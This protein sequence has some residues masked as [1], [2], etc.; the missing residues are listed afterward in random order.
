MQWLRI[1]DVSTGGHGGVTSGPS[2]RPVMI[3]GAI[4]RRIGIGRRK[5]LDRGWATQCALIV[6]K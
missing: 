5:A 2:N 1:H 3:H 4:G 6:L